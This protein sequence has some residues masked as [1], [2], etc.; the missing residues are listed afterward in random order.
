MELLYTFIECSIAI[1][2]FSSIVAQF[3]KTKSNEWNLRQYQGIIAHSIQAFIYSCLP[4]LLKEFPI[5]SDLIWKICTM[6]LGVFTFIQAIGV[7]AT[8]KKSKSIAKISMLSL[9]L[10]ILLLQL[11]YVLGYINSGIAVYNVGIFWHLFQSIYLIA[12]FIF[13]VDE[14]QQIQH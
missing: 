6:I 10:L 14:D 9:S 13:Q 5:P 7:M 1:L 2:A 3:K 12:S 11:A 8:D 4:L